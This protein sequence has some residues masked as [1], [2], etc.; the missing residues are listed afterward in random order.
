MKQTIIPKEAF[1][2]G[3]NLSRDFIQFNLHEIFCVQPSLN[4]N[5]DSPENKI[6][7][8]YATKHRKTVFKL[9]HW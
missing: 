2:K 7:K 8:L 3:K 4:Y 6:Q 5:M 9:A 1:S